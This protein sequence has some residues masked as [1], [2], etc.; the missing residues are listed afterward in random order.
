MLSFTVELTTA[1]QSSYE[2]SDGAIRKLQSVL[3]A[4]ARLVTG[5]RQNEHIMPTFRDVLQWLPVKQ[6]ITY[7]IAMMAFSCV[8]GTCPAYFSDVCTP[9]QTVA[10]RA[11]LCSACHGH[12]IFPATKMK[13]FGIHSFRVL[14][15]SG[16]VYPLTFSASTQVK[17]NCK[18]TWLFG[19]AS[20]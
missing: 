3:H 1:T 9:V 4:A 15:L 16:T 11:K 12:P 6:R 8:R 17:D 2:V 5:V 7:K 20:K 19:C 18:R 10:G 13:I 14:L